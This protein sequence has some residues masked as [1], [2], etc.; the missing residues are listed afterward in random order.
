MTIY[1]Y[2]VYAYLDSSNI[3]YYIGKGTRGRAWSTQHSVPLPTDL[4]KIVILEDNLSE[5]GARA[6]E[7]RM[8][9]WYGRKDMGEGPLLNK[10]VGGSGISYHTPESRKK[11][12]EALKGRVP[13]NVG[14]TGYKNRPSGK[15]N[16]SK[17]KKRPHYSKRRVQ[18]PPKIVSCSKCE[19]TANAGNFGRWHKNCG[20]PVAI[21]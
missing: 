9:N 11:L 13:W 17:G 6:I 3:P 16:P 2:Y 8:I 5:I 10:K 21:S 15:P 20:E 12:S 18:H 7:R 1:R 14:V 19:Y 4:S